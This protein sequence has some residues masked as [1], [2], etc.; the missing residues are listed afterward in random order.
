MGFYKKLED[1]SIQQSQVAKDLHTLAFPNNDENLP[2]AE[3][4]DVDETGTQYDNDQ[5]Y[6]QRLGDGPA[7]T[8][9]PS[10]EPSS[11]I[12]STPVP[13]ASFTMS[14]CLQS[15]KV[16]T[17]PSGPADEMVTGPSGPDNSS[18]VLSPSIPAS[19]TVV[20]PVTSIPPQPLHENKRSP[21]VTMTSPMPI[22]SQDDDQAT[23]MIL[24]SNHLS[25]PTNITPSVDHIS[26][27]PS[28]GAN[29][30]AKR[31]CGHTPTIGERR[32]PRIRDIS[33]A[34]T[35]AMDI[36]TKR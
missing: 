26:S 34:P 7:P 20:C 31:H 36:T 28:D 4:D 12:P 3:D 30:K 10:P 21:T 16:T 18:S 17:A 15:Q 23:T 9:F 5:R 11:E 33:H 24:P 29:P 22:N 6:D 27:P 13:S 1:L 25:P 35:L 14:K 2:A 8:L 19:T 32:S